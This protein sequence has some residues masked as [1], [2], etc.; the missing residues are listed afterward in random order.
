[1]VTPP[2]CSSRLLNIIMVITRSPNCQIDFLTRIFLTF[3]QLRLSAITTQE[4]L[5]T[6][7][8]RIGERSRSL[9]LYPNAL[10]TTFIPTPRNKSVKTI[11]R[12]GTSSFRNRRIFSL[13]YSLCELL[14]LSLTCRRVTRYPAP[15]PTAVIGRFSIINFQAGI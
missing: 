1:M 2:L 7:P 8:S 6:S 13:E 3:S 15:S 14:A 10:H 5:N 4:K 12:I 11:R 9:D